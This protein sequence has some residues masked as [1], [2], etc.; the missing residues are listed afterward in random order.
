MY[1]YVGNCRPRWK[2]AP[3]VIA[4]GVVLLLL[5]SGALS[6]T[7]DLGRSSRL[8]ATHSTRRLIGTPAPVPPISTPLPGAPPPFKHAGNSSWA[9][10]NPPSARQG[11][12]FASDPKD[13][14]TLLFGGWNGSAYFGDTWEF[15]LNEW[16]ELTPSPSPSP[17][18]GASLTYDNHDGYMVLF[19]GVNASG[20]L[21]D[22]WAFV[23]GS[24]TKLATAVAPSARG[25]ATM[26]YD[27]TAG[28]AYVVLFGGKNDTGT[29]SD[30]WKFVHG[31]WSRV[32]TGAIAPI[33]RSDA[34]MAYDAHDASI[35]LFGG[36][37]DS[38]S[39]PLPIPTTNPPIYLNDTWTYVAG[40]WTHM[41]TPTAPSPRADFA[42]VYAPSSNVIVLFGGTDLTLSTDYGDTWTYTAGAW[43]FV[44]E[45]SA[46][47]ARSGSEAA[48]DAIDNYTLV[49]GGSADGSVGLM[50]AWSFSGGVWSVIQSIPKF[51]WP[52][53]ADRSFASMV[54]DYA[55]QYNVLFG[56]Q[57][58]LGASA[59]TWTFSNQVWT[60]LFPSVAPSAR[61]YS[62]MAF[63]AR[64]G[65]VL[66]FGGR[67]ASGTSLGDTWEFKAGV[68]TQLHPVT[69]PTARYG[70][71]MTF[72]EADN[73][74]ILFGGTTGSGAFL[75]DT[76]AF[77]AGAWTQLTP[78]G[79]PSARA[80]SGFTYDATDGY[81]LLYGGLNASVLGDTWS[82]VGG[83]WTRLT[84]VTSPPPLWDA[85]LQFASNA[86]ADYVF[87]GCTIA[88]TN[89]TS[90]V[91]AVPYA[92]T[93][94]FYSG[95]WH[96][97]TTVSGGGAISPAAEFGMASS[98]DLGDKGVVYFGGLTAT[99]LT[100]TRWIIDGNSWT[101]WFPIL[102]PAARTGMAATYS[103]RDDH[104]IFFGG[105]GPVP[106]GGL[107]FYSDTWQWDTEVW[108][109]AQPHHSPS[110]RAWASVA[111]SGGQKIPQGANLTVLFGGYG[112]SG[113]LGDTWTWTGG[114]TTGGWTQVRTLVA[115]S[116]RSNASM[117]F[118]IA[119]DSIIL[120]GGQNTT[121]V[122]NDTW[123]F[124]GTAWTQLHP[125]GP[126]PAR[127]SANM[128][129]DI[130][131]NELILFGGINTTSKTVFGD[132]WTFAGGVW[133]QLHPTTA[134]PA[135]YGAAMDWAFPTS[136]GS[137]DYVLL[138]GGKSAT[139]GYLGDTWQFVRGTWTQLE[140][141]KRG[142]PLPAMG[143]IMGDDT[144]DG[145]PVL[146]GGFD[147]SY[148]GAFW[149]F[150]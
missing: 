49:A 131:D 147:G 142:T 30:T 64:D 126:P 56:G 96:L 38:P 23:N 95:K 63:D 111:Y 146:F 99:G 17:R 141:G 132:T 138:F 22:T 66:L 45:S 39:I 118:D 46:P 100:L 3:A 80:F 108:G 52:E 93:M 11:A 9:A 79:P 68:W 7:G 27:A 53:P 87:G 140:V 101:E 125:S 114:V 88:T 58:A 85:G 81:V 32:A 21:N 37:N 13:R 72:D 20:P 71:E 74:T 135:R 77:K 26:T 70:A 121:G 83:V 112:P 60:E 139:G 55:D 10:S 67:N 36:I 25:F 14:I 148:L 16:I 4:V 106:A 44:P 90:G 42:F 24:W 73:E 28:D 1:R 89:P 119:T 127:A 65:Y 6:S 33:G 69:G 143:V 133:T 128:V 144:T 97:L 19:G 122:L 50:D 94:K 75:S 5:F 103:T 47:S 8:I 150:R 134:P 116:A 117:W 110:A 113:Y 43:T 129:F 76:W 123:S 12:A 109:K 15:V 137:Y 29:L 57:T 51:F 48:W 82:F 40:T 120:F 86:G 105:Y 136:K 91:C 145:S 98:Y 130:Q 31:A 61:A 41:V 92:G 35:V 107:G 115:P 102:F 124:N 59:E 84:E 34:G 62:A 149:V 54:D 104:I 78:S 18:E 2:V